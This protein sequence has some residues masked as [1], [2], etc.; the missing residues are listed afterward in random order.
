MTQL[1]HSKEFMK[2]EGTAVVC[3]T[4]MVKGDLDVSGRPEHLRRSLT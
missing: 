2:E 3:Q 4:R 1:Q